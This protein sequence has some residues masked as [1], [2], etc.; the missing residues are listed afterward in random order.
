VHLETPVQI[1]PGE[2]VDQAETILE[3]AA[4]FAGPVVIAGDFNGEEIGVTMRQAGYRW[5]T[6]RV[7]PTVSFFSWDHIFVRGLL[8]ARPGPSA[9]VVRRVDGASDHRPIWAALAWTPHA[10]SPPTAVPVTPVRMEP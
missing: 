10:V 7:G 6:D 5:L 1:T 3:D 2:R 9:G 8:P 4:S